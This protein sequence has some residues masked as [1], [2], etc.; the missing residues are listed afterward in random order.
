MK[1]GYVM[2]R[3]GR[4][5]EHID[6]FGGLSQLSNGEQ[7]EYKRLK[8]YLMIFKALIECGFTPHDAEQS[9]KYFNKEE[10]ELC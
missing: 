10:Q 1:L 7:N 6:T 8:D 5:E 3:I 4:I 2:Y 9:V